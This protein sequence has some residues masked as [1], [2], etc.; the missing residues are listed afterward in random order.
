MR[1]IFLLVMILLIF[2]VGCNNYENEVF[3]DWGSMNDAK[4]VDGYV[5]VYE[6]NE[7][8]IIER[9]DYVEM[10]FERERVD[11]VY[12]EKRVRYYYDLSGEIELNLE[13]EGEFVFT[14]PK[15]FALSVSDI[16]FSVE[17][18][19]IIN[20]D[21]VVKWMV[22][23]SD[24]RLKKVVLKVKEAAFV[25]GREATLSSLGNFFSGQK[26]D[27][28]KVN[29]AMIDSGSDNLLEHLD[30][31][32]FV[33]DLDFCARKNTDGERMLCVMKMVDKHPEWFD[34]DE[35]F[36]DNE[37][38]RL[39]CRAV[40]IDDS[41]ECK[42]SNS[43]EYRDDDAFACKYNLFKTKSNECEHMFS[44]KRIECFKQVALDS[45]YSDGCLKIADED[46]RKDC[47]MRFND[48]YVAVEKDSDAKESR[49]S[50]KDTAESSYDWDEGK[51]GKTEKEFC[52]S[53]QI[54]CKGWKTFG[55]Q[56]RYFKDLH[57]RCTPDG[58]V[59]YC[60]NDFCQ[61]ITLRSES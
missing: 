3:Y 16:D 41:S 38:L 6:F 21:P 10:K 17:P 40:R 26:I 29:K 4:N 1:H 42:G 27:L 39:T 22:R 61:G 54:Y 34:C 49:D 31:F 9:D 8:E 14:I 50:N 15:S 45:G 37:I 36:S 58:E 5:E 32:I 57:C 2:L 59:E 28:S 18:D 11:G 43:D 44:D 23:E 20:D 30:D 60:E 7:P 33:A 51:Y 12:V 55:M 52:E 19:E 24:K 56:T 48:D 47:K 13:G 35:M 53:V 46:E 25:A